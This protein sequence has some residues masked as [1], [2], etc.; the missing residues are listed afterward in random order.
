[1]ND[2]R[3]WISLNDSRRPRESIARYAWRRSI[4]RALDDLAIPRRRPLERRIVEVKE[5]VKVERVSIDVALAT[6]Q[7]AGRRSLK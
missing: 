4:L 7:R 3:R 5:P 6:T 1:M 2:P